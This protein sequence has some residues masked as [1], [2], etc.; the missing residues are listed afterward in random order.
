MSLTGTP[1]FLRV[2]KQAIL[3]DPIA[4][5]AHGILYA[6]SAVPQEQNYCLHTSS[7]SEPAIRKFIGRVIEVTHPRAKNSLRQTVA[8]FVTVT[9]H[10]SSQLPLSQVTRE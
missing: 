10:S 2:E 7:I 6:Y 3:F 9:C 8:G 1:V 5:K 4:G